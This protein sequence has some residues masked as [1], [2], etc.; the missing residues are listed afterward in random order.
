[1]LVVLDGAYKLSCQA[2]VVEGCT[3]EVMIRTIITLHRLVV[4]GILLNKMLRLLRLKIQLTANNRHNLH[5]EPM[6]LDLTWSASTPVVTQT[7]MPQGSSKSIPFFL[8]SAQVPRFQDPKVGA[9]KLFS[10]AV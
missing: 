1:M 3:F 5:R 9:K 6:A 2:G 8:P 4:L 10:S 7:S